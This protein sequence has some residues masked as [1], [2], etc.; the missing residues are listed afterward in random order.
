LKFVSLSRNDDG[1]G[2]DYGSTR[3]LKARAKLRY[4]HD[5]DYFFKDFRYPEVNSGYWKVQDASIEC[6]VVGY[7]FAQEG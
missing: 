7:K 4:P 3:V 6:C 2:P 1:S 5:C